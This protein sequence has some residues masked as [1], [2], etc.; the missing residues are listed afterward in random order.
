MLNR[1]IHFSVKNKFIVLLCIIGWVVWGAVE[2]LRLPMDALPDIT[3]NQVQ[4]ITVSPTLGAMEVERLITFPIEQAS[5]NIPGITEI[6]SISRFGL[7]VVTLVFQDDRDVYRCRQQVAERMS[8]IRS[9]IPPEAGSPELAPVTTGLGEIYQ[10]VVK[11]KKGYEDRYNLTE[12]RTIQDWIIRRQ[13]LGTPGVADVSSFGGKLKQYEVAIEPGRIQSLGISL[14]Q[15]YEALQKNNQNSGAAY[16]EK[17]PSLLFIRSEGMAR[18]IE[19]IGNIRVAAAASGTP[20]LIR[21]IAEVRIGSP[22]RYGALTYQDQGEV[23]GAVVL[24]L[25][26]ANASE[27]VKGI[28]LRMRQIEKSLPEGVEIKTFL[29]RRKMVTRTLN[30]VK[31]NLL[32]GALIVLFVLI[33]FLGNFRAGL[34]VASVIPLAM[35]FAVGMMNVFGVS[36]NL[37][38]LGALDFGLIVDGAVIIVEAVLCQLHIR[39]PG[40]AGLSQQE[41][42]DTVIESSGRMMNAAVFGQ[43]IILVVYIPILSLS[44]IEGKMFQ[45]MAQTVIFA[46]IGAFL[47]SV[48]YVPMI[49]SWVIPK[50]SQQHFWFSERLMEAIQSGFQRLLKRLLL[51]PGKVIFIAAGFL[52]FSLFIAARLGGEFIPELEEGDFAVDA[53]LMTGSSLQETINATQEAVHELKKFPEVTS[54]VT[55]IGAS[56]IP[57]D[58]MP[59]EMTD[60]IINLKEKGLWTSATSYEE[61]ANKMSEA[62]AK[63]PRLS[64]GFQY[65][66]QMRFNE[67]IAGSKQ[68]VVCKLFGE[69]IDTLA[70]YASI[71]E[72]LIVQ[73]EGAKDVFAERVTGLPQVV[74]RL[75]K[76]ALAAYGFDVE[77]VNRTIRTAFA[78]EVAG[79]VYEN[80]RKFDLVVR[81]KKSSRDELTDLSTLILST[82]SG[83]QVPLAQVADVIIE[84]GPN[85]IQREDAKR[86]ITVG[87]NVRDRDVQSVVE[88]VRKRIDRSVSLPAGYYVQFGGQFEN[89]TEAKNRLMIAVPVALLLIF[90]IL[91][92]SFGSV[93][94]GLLIYTAIPLSAIGGILLLWLRDMPFSISAGI[95]FI[96]LFGVSV[97]NGIVLISEFIRLEKQ[98]NKDVW[99]IVLEGSVTRLRPVL[100]TAAVASLGFLPMALSD[101]SGAEVQRPL[102]TVVIGGLISATL[103]TLIVLPMLYVWVSKMKRMPPRVGL[104][105]LVLICAPFLTKAQS[106]TYVPL[107]VD[108]IVAYTEKNA[109][110]VQVARRKILA[111][112]AA[113][114]QYRE[115]S[116]TSVLIE[117]GKINSLFNDSKFSFSQPLQLPVVYRRQEAAQAA[118]LRVERAQQSANLA[119]YKLD[120]RKTC[121]QIMDLQR[122][123]MILQE[124]ETLFKEWERITQVQL[125]EGETARSVAQAIRLQSADM[126]LQ[127]EQLENDR[128]ALINDLRQSTNS[129]ELFY[130]VL[131]NAFISIQTTPDF[132]LSRHPQ[133]TTS[134]ENIAARKMDVGLAKSRLSPEFSFGYQSQTIIGWQSPDGENIKYFGA[135]KRF[136]VVEFGLNFPIFSNTL[137][138]KIKSADLEQQ[139]AEIQHEQLVSTFDNYYVNVIIRYIQAKKAIDYY[140]R[141]GLKTADDLFRQAGIRLKAGDISYAEW[142]L[143]VSQSL[144]IKLSYA[145]AVL[146]MQLITADYQYLQEKQ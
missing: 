55:R 17:G 43:F 86:R 122:R 143:L 22:I 137:K 23:S 84:E 92:F 58:P 70:K 73:V 60:I 85:Q 62:I 50:K 128:I 61:L 115:V 136:G 118:G 18:S 57:T 35:L 110:I 63:V 66:V 132:S 126:T 103:L 112:E 120:I 15:V 135:G 139:I 65:P 98:G 14:D 8:A 13:L 12:L 87:F 59:I 7:S 56:E 95:G 106:T 105:A 102:A 6:R 89:L 69:N 53:R 33:I 25:K 130:P 38:S 26:G 1:I 31:T 79:K 32:E 54:I 117:Y 114:K 28:E 76:D 78:G 27:V 88:D 49:S 121:Y 127:K 10:Y 11:P 9:E 51:H 34:I 82:P 83:K 5:S 16:I 39:K 96:A 116:P 4:V 72:K 37:M 40:Q 52:V 109:A 47:L 131:T 141:D 138:A 140:E 146:Q 134:L 24:M 101:S 111:S 144:Q 68:D 71:I 124:M 108:S 81:F 41:M 104:S 36:G 29:D 90:L 113:V 107:S 67:L 129:E 48:T 77:Q 3:S 74:I 93:K 133:I 80:E 19:E 42:D 99:T 75:K 64:A 44:G 100:M 91:Y 119:D 30:T 20:I 125:K 45:P 94:Y 142:M 2:L 97:L 145:S 21:D 123:F 46:L